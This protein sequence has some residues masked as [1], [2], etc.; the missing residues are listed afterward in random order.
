MTLIIILFS[1]ELLLL[2]ENVLGFRLLSTTDFGEALSR[3]SLIWNNCWWTI[4]C[5]LAIISN[6]PMFLSKHIFPRLLF[7]THNIKA[8]KILTSLWFDLSIIFLIPI[9]KRASNQIILCNQLF[10]QFILCFDEIHSL[11]Y[12]SFGF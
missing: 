1:G 3:V 11:F 2:F 8:S 6:D 9:L 7:P 12:I 5:N 4:S 10:T